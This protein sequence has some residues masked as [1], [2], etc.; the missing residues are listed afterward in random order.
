MASARRAEPGGARPRGEL[1]GEQA[2]RQNPQPTLTS[3]KDKRAVAQR[4]RRERAQDCVVMNASGGDSHIGEAALDDTTKRP[5][6]PA[7]AQLALEAFA[8]SADAG[9][10]VAGRLALDD[11]SVG[12]EAK[13]KSPVSS[14]ARSRLQPCGRVSLPGMIGR[15]PRITKHDHAMRRDLK[16]AAHCS[17]IATSL[18][19]SACSARPPG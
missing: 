17:W 12:C 8:A 2:T 1:G 16:N 15:F 10:Q 3:G 14:A 6:V 18:A 11:S 5:A 19:E 13:Q 7:S 4:P 9:G